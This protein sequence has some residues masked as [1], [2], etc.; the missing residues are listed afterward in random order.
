VEVQAGG[1]VLIGLREAAMAGAA[2]GIVL[3][4]LGPS[5]DHR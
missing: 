3:T 4:L 5:I 2:V 1:R